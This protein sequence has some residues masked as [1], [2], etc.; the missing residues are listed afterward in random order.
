MADALRNMMIK[1]YMKD[2]SPENALKHVKSLILLAMKNKL[3]LD[4]ILRGEIIVTIITNYQEFL[5]GMSDDDTSTLMMMVADKDSYV[6]P[7]SIADPDDGN[8]AGAFLK[9]FDNMALEWEN[10]VRERAAAQ[11]RYMKLAQED[12]HH[13]MEILQTRSKSILSSVSNISAV[14]PVVESGSL[15]PILNVSLESPI[16]PDVSKPSLPV[17]ESVEPI[18]P[19]DS[20]K[21]MSVDIDTSKHTIM[22]DIDMSDVNLSD[23]TIEI[24][25]KNLPVPPLT[26]NE[27]V[28]EILVCVPKTAGE[29]LETVQYFANEPTESVPTPSQILKPKSDI[30]PVDKDDDLLLSELTKHMGDSVLRIVR[31]EHLFVTGTAHPEST[32]F[33]IRDVQNILTSTHPT[34]SETSHSVSTTPVDVSPKKESRKPKRKVSKSADPPVQ[35]VFKNLRSSVKGKAPS[36]P[37]TVKKGKSVKGSSKPKARSAT[38]TGLP[39]APENIDTVE[40]QPKFVDE[41]VES[42]WE[43]MIRRELIV[44][45]S[46]DIKQMNSVC[47]VVPLLK[48]AGL[49]NTVYKI[50]PYSKLLTYEFY[51][52]LSESIDDLTHE[53][54]LQVCARKS[55]YVFGLNVINEYYKLPVVD[56]E[57]ID[58]WDQVAKT[59][60]SGIL[61]EWP[62]SDSDALSSLI[63]RIGTKKPVDLGKWIFDHVLTLVHPREQK[64]KLPYPNLIY[65]WLTSQGLVPLANETVRTSLTY[66]MD[67]RLLSG[68]HIRDVQPVNPPQSTS[69]DHVDNTPYVNNLR[70]SKILKIHVDALQA[71]SAIINT[72]LHAAR[73]KLAIVLLRLILANAEPAQDTAHSA[74]EKGPSVN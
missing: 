50:G 34:T 58:D 53:R 21:S 60:T 11:E 37:L 29:H 8:R 66:T 64:V 62:S 57:E 73:T 42:K 12:A 6:T 35:Q 9:Y 47:D 18:L 27:P 71:A 2:H 67:S 10:I 43:S 44:Q 26:H 22:P 4:P 41:V 33:K 30:P 24:P 40:Y 56:D 7:A 74:D 23:V 59:L 20:S 15:A 19:I 16:V 72:Q 3:K 17:S 55:W 5:E 46:I 39:S 51:C 48:E 68:K 1:V 49:I 13:R 70:L 14:K 36:V 63:Y 54:C 38:P 31:E 61:T 25:S 32:S 65:G 28:T 52:N 69:D 45:R